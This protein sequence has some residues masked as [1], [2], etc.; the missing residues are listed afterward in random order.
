MYD[1]AYLVWIR[2]QVKM[3]AVYIFK[4]NDKTMIAVI[5]TVNLFA[6]SEKNTKNRNDQ[7]DLVN[8][9]SCH[10]LKWYL[11][12]ALRVNFVVSMSRCI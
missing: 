10:Q 1:R 3:K 2:R 9:S 6:Y 5:S 8:L 7:Q 11:P 4:K 12:T